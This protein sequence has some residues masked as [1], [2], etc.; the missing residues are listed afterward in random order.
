MGQTTEGAKP[1]EGRVRPD[2]TVHWLLARDTV[3]AHRAR[4][5]VIARENLTSVLHKYAHHV[6]DTTSLDVELKRAERNL[7]D[8]AG[9]VARWLIDTTFGGIVP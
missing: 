2:Q 3:L 9:D 1:T 4:V 5:F 8:A 6:G 7:D